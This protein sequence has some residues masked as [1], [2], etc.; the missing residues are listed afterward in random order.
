[1]SVERYVSY[2]IICDLC[3]DATYTGF[4]GVDRA[5]VKRDAKREGWKT[6]TGTDYCP[7]CLTD[8]SQGRYFQ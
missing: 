4:P 5:D 8:I 7:K 6:I 2:E 3:V 1:M